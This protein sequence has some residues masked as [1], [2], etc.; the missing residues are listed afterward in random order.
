MAHAAAPYTVSLDPDQARQLATAGAALLLLDVPEGT[1]L[2]IDQ[3]VFAVGPRFKGVKL[4]PPGVHFLSYQATAR[5]GRVSPAVSTFLVLKGGDVAVRRW[6][7]ADEGLQPL[8]DDDEVRSCWALWVP[9]W[10]RNEAVVAT[11]HKPPLL[12]PKRRRWRA[13]QRACGALTLTRASPP[14]TWRRTPSGAA[15]P[16]SSTSRCC[17]GCCR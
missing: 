8:A 1:L 4:V 10:S 2:G 15:S 3:Q 5:D 17:A 13:M 6:S 9:R 7:P 14:T 11:V 16:A 12:S